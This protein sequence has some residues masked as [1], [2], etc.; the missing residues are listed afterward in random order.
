[1]EKKKKTE[2]E[3]LSC[4]YKIWAAPVTYATAVATLDP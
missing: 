4:T 3:K 1:M 2:K